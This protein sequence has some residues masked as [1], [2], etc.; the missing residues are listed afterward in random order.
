MADR[1]TSDDPRDQAGNAGDEARADAHLTK[2]N[3]M[4]GA[5]RA[6]R[7]A[8]TGGREVER[9]AEQHP[10]AVA[11]GAATGAAGG[12]VLGGPPGAVIGA[13]TGAARGLAAADALDVAKKGVSKKRA[14]DSTNSGRARGGNGR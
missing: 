12:A 5:Q 10:K 4:A 1:R 9:D 2:R 13:I 14:T 6:G 8:K 7:D 11:G 3:P